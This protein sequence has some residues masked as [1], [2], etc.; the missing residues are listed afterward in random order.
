MDSEGLQRHWGAEG[1]TDAMEHG[2]GIWK[3]ATNL[4]DFERKVWPLT[5][6][7]IT[8]DLKVFG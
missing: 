5:S 6:L 4:E 8:A 2:E 1:R 7:D 3:W